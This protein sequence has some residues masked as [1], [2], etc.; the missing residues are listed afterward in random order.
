MKLVVVV[1][2]YNEARVIGKVIRAVPKS[3]PSVGRTTVVVIDDGS[4]DNTGL[5]AKKAG[6]IVLRH[7]LNRG[8][9]VALSTGFRAVQLLRAGAVITI[10][11]DGQHDPAEIPILLAPILRKEADLVIG[12][13]LLHKNGHMPLERLLA[14]QFS[15]IV[16]RFM[17]GAIV[18]DSQSGYRA[19]SKRA[20]Q[21]LRFA[22]RGFEVETETLAQARL[23]RLQIAEV[24]IRTIYT[25]YSRSKG[26]RFAHGITM[27]IRMMMA[28]LRGF[29]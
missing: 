19:F 4:T 23:R 25:P 28:H 27:T 18:T 22:S 15:N 17:S 2:A 1:P 21:E 10:D 6:A 5:T 24:P 16:T 13:R 8:K 20:L 11:A 7:R 3:L 12:S 29:R 14:N 9:G 26:Q